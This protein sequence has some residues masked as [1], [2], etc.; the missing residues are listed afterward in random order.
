MAGVQRGDCIFNYQGRSLYLRLTLGALAEICA[1]LNVKNI[2]ELSKRI[3]DADRDHIIF[4][5]GAL[6]RSAHHEEPDFSDL[7]LHEA[8]PVLADVFETA[9]APLSAGDAK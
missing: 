5:F 4:I 1:R 7:N 6:S 9:F 2:F 3:R 8:M